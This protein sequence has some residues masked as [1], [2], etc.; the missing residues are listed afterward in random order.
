MAFFKAKYASPVLF[1]RQTYLFLLLHIFQE[2]NHL[3]ITS[4]ICLRLE[5]KIFHIIF[6]F[7]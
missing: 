7:T 2:K 5:T 4:N 3:V 6:T 1:T